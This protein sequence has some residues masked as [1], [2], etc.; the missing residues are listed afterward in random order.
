M[1]SSN[2]QLNTVLFLAA[3]AAGAYFIFRKP[4]DKNDVYFDAKFAAANTETQRLI[5]EREKWVD[6]E[7]AY[8][9][10]KDAQQTWIDNWR[11]EHGGLGYNGGLANIPV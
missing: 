5:A 10:H 6:H 1:S 2:S 11:S 9:K 3:A 7:Y 4:K 8:W